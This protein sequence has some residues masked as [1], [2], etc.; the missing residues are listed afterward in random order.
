VREREEDRPLEE[1]RLVRGQRL[2]QQEEVA[3]P[4]GGGEGRED[5]RQRGG[6][7]AREELLGGQAGEEQVG[8]DEVGQD[9]GAVGGEARRGLE[10]GRLEAV[11]SAEEVV[12]GEV[13][14]AEVVEEGD[15]LGRRVQRQRRGV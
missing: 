14:A 1:P 2:L 6:L 9:E 4:D 5:G 15:P 12:V 11:G 7:R 13:E 3:R 8:G 10:V